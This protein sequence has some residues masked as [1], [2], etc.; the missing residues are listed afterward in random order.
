M[1]VCRVVVVAWILPDDFPIESYDDTFSTK[2]R[3]SGEGRRR[4]AGRLIGY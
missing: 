1:M 3:V 4:G 2:K